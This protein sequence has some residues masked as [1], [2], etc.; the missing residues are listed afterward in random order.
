MT[1][2][3]K[4]LLTILLVTGLGLI[5]AGMYDISHRAESNVKRQACAICD[6]VRQAK[7]CVPFCVKDGRHYQ[8]CCHMAC[9]HPEFGTVNAR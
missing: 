3:G 1:T 8:H 9:V 4:I 6:C 2:T 7:D 5:L